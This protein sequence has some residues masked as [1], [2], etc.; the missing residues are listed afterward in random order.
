MKTL[1]LV[2]TSPIW[3]PFWVLYQIIT[4][5]SHKPPKDQGGTKSHKGWLG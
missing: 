3:F 4:A 5:P 1:L 2:I